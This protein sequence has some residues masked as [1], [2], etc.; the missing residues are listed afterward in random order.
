LHDGFCWGGL[1]TLALERLVLFNQNVCTRPEK[2][3]ARKDED[4]L[5]RERRPFL[6]RAIPAE[7]KMDDAAHFNDGDSAFKL[8]RFPVNRQRK[9]SWCC[10]CFSGLK[11]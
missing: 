4:C 6:A 11:A 1:L 2:E 7:F 3:H 10:G 8:D 9:I 5:R